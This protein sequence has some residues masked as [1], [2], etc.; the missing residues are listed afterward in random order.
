MAHLIWSRENSTSVSVSIT[1]S[2]TP[3][4][5][6]ISFS[7]PSSS[8]MHRRDATLFPSLDGQSTSACIHS[9]LFNVDSLGQLSVVNAG[10]SMTYSTSGDVTSAP[11]APSST[12]SNISTTWELAAGALSWKNSL[13]YNGTASLCTDPTGVVQAYFLAPIPADCTPISL[14]QTS[15]PWFS[16][17]NNEQHY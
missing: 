15:G 7:A 2:S 13:F 17:L 1:P 9:P 6:L 5:F 12:I 4:G 8:R 11:F 10:T 16:L 14:S 3:A